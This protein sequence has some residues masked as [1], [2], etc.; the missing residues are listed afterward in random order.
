MPR[1]RCCKTSRSMFLGGSVKDVAC[2][3]GGTSLG[4]CIVKDVK[5]V[6][7]PARQGVFVCATSYCPI[8]RRLS[9]SIILTAEAT[10]LK[11]PAQS[12]ASWRSV[13]TAKVGSYCLRVVGIM[14]SSACFAL[15]PPRQIGT[16]VEFAA[17]MEMT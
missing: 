6:V 13:P 1:P 4:V 11:R 10:G 7:V 5:N 2:V 14:L 15:T 8:H 12:P 16:Q 3:Y 17:S 9:I